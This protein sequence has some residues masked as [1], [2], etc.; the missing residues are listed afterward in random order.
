MEISQL[1]YW[2]DRLFYK[3]ALCKP[4]MLK[5]RTNKDHFHYKMRGNASDR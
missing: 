5:Y 4:S 3:L 2:A 1:D